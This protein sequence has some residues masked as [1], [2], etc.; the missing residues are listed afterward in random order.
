MSKQ[1]LKAGVG[2]LIV[3]HRDVRITDATRAFGCPE[4]EINHA[5]A[6][7]HSVLRQHGYIRSRRWR[8]LERVFRLLRYVWNTAN[9]HHHSS[10][11]VNRYFT[12]R[13]TIR[14]E[15]NFRAPKI[16]R[17]LII[18]S[19]KRSDTSPKYLTN[20]RL[21]NINS[22]L[23]LNNRVHGLDAS[24]QNTTDLRLTCVER[25]VQRLV[26]KRIRIEENTFHRT[27]ERTLVSPKTEYV[28][29]APPVP[30]KAPRPRAERS[31]KPSVPIQQTNDFLEAS[32]RSMMP[33]KRADTEKIAPVDVDR[34]TEQ[35]V[36][37]IDQR[38]IAQRERMGRG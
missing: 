21:Q 27:A 36:R 33:R 30:R 2:N 28:R 1:P 5:Y 6:F 24:R 29:A 25:L 22:A 38:I 20:I 13:L 15:L 4:G 10:L 23:P 17:H 35:V 34:L 7:A 11:G 31:S 9:R 14:P 12:A 37:A 26:K 32:N 8:R 19:M 3:V 18:W 16:R